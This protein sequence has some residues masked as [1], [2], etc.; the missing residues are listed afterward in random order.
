[1]WSRYVY[2]CGKTAKVERDWKWYCGIHDPVAVDARGEKYRAKSGA[3]WA[4]RAAQWN[5]ERAAPEMKAALEFI[6]DNS[7]DPVME[8]V[9][10][11]AIAKA[12]NRS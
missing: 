2:E 6:R 11:A 5:L 4:E 7:G 10:R 3:K 1:M 8:N 9:A 12:E